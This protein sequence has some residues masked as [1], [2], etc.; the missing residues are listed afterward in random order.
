[1]VAVMP[2][3]LGKLARVARSIGRRLPMRVLVMVVFVG[4]NAESR[5]VFADVPVH[6]GRRRP[7]EL[8]RN[9]EHDE[10]GDEAAHGWH[11]TQ[12]I[13]AA[14][15]RSLAGAP[16]V[17][18][19]RCVRTALASERLNDVARHAA[20]RQVLRQACDVGGIQQ[21]RMHGGADFMGN[22]GS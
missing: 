6:A 9:D 3:L 19:Q 14:K 13:L 7:G 17:L 20:C 16:R 4:M 8:E 2:V 12:L 1:M 10:E 22:A 5:H 11:S 18:N 15:I 21:G